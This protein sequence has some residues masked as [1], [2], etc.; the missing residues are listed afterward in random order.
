MLAPCSSI[1]ACHQAGADAWPEIEVP[2]AAFEALVG[3]RFHATTDV[4]L[5]A[6]ELYLACGCALGD[7][8]ALGVFERQIAGGLPAALRRMRIDDDDAAD[9]QQQLRVRLFTATAGEVPRIVA[10]AGTGRL[11]A[12]V[13]V[14]ATRLAL[15]VKRSQRRRDAAPIDDQLAAGIAPSADVVTLLNKAELRNALRLAFEQAAAHLPRRDRTLLRMSVLDGLTIDELATMHRVHRATVARWLVT[16]REQLTADARRRFV[17]LADLEDIE[18]GQAGELIES[19]LS[20]SLERLL[21]S[22]T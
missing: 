21:R 3:E 13:H 9:V 7:A 19:Q 18:I 1:R 4:E 10:Y 17:E 8:R 16:A 11:G 20:V 12:L 22:R 6:S 15:D 5:D 2:F 14:A